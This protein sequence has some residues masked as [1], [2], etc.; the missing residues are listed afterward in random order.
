MRAIARAISGTTFMRVR[1]ASKSSWIKEKKRERERETYI[2]YKRENTT[3]N[4]E[5][6]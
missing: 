1:G 2:V 3:R 5:K 6:R 4:K